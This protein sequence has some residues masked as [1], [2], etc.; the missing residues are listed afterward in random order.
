MTGDQTQ[1]RYR[2]QKI[3]EKNGL[4]GTVKVRT[5]KRITD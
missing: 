3:K 2:K 1:T 4:I 5:R